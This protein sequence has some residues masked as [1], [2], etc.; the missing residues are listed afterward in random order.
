[1]TKRLKI[2]LSVLVL[3]MTGQLCYSYLEGSAYDAYAESD[4]CRLF[5]SLVMELGLK[6]AIG[7]EALRNDEEGDFFFLRVA[8]WIGT[9]QASRDCVDIED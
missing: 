5:P 3:L 9:E 4:N 7:L 6:K 1:M 2:L 8:K